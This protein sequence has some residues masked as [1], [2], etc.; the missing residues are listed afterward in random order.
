MYKMT[1]HCSEE[2]ALSI[3]VALLRMVVTMHRCGIIHGDI[4]PDNILLFERYLLVFLWMLEHRLPS[5]SCLGLGLAFRDFE[6]QVKQ[7][8][9]SKNRKQILMRTE[10]NTMLVLML[11]LTFITISCHQ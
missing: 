2:I 8:K 4:K 5:L 9:P 10:R 7:L 3:A 11:I 1:S 6:S